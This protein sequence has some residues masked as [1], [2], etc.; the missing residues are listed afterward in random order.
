M[1]PTLTVRL[2]WLYEQALTDLLTDIDLPKRPTEIGLIRG[3]FLDPTASHLIINTTLGDNYYLHTQS[4]QPKALSRL[5]GVSIE[6][7]AWNPSH[8][9][10]STREILVAASDGNIYE[11]SIE[12]ANEFYRREEK[13]LRSV[14]KLPDGQPVTGIWVNIPGDRPEFRRV[15]IATSTKLLHFV[16][17]IGK[18]STDGS[19][20]IFAKF[21]DAERPTVQEG[22]E[23]ATSA[24]SFLAFSPDPTNDRSRDAGAP[25][26][27]YA[28][29]TIQGV[30][31]GKINPSTDISKLGTRMF[32]SSRLFERSRIPPSAA[33]SGRQTTSV[34]EPIKG[35]AMT[36]W[37]ILCI[38]EGRVV[39]INR[40]NEQVVYDQAVLEPGDKAIGLFAD[41]KKSTFW[42]FTSQEIFEISVQDEDRDI[43]KIMLREQKFEAA[44]QYA[45]GS[46]QKDAVATAS[47]DHLIGKKQYLEAASVY[48]KSSKPFEEVALVFIDND[49]A[50]AL[51]KYLLTKI[52][53]YK[54][55]QIMQRTM[56]ASWLVEIFMAKLNSLDDTITTK[57]ELVEGMNMSDTE[58]ELASIRRE[59]G[60]FLSKYKGDLD[61]KTTY[62][63][64][65]S[66]GREQELLAYATAINDYGYALSYWVQRERWKDVLDVL[67]KQ[68]N[69]AVFYKYGS[70]LMTHVPTE[71]VDILMR[72]TNLEPRN[73]IPA[74]LSYAKDHPGPLAQNQAARYL[75][76]CIN[77][78]GTTDAAV[79]NTLISIYAAH[80]S[81]S[82]QALMS[83]LSAQSAHPPP[84]YDA[85]FALRLCIQHNRV[86][87]CVHIY[88]LMS[89]YVEA[90]NLAL[91]HDEI[92]LAT[93]VA[94]RPAT[95]NPALRKKLWLAIA[96][97]V[98]THDG[99]GSV[100][101]A[102]DL[103]KRC[104]LL[105][106]E[107]L[108]PF[109]PD[110]VVIDDFKDEICAALES[111]SRHIDALA[112]DMDAAAAT[113]ASIRADV[114]R[115]DQRYAVVLPGERCRVCALPL[116][117]RQFF[118]FPSCQHGFH[119]DC[120]GRKVVEGSGL[121][122]R[123]RI[124]E[125]QASIGRGVQGARR[126]REVKELDALV[127]K[128]WYVI[129]G[130]GGCKTQWANACVQCAMQ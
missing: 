4:R 115:L 113:A 111:Y 79:H 20:S 114:K 30:R 17:K 55:S 51:R 125:L 74:L 130:F 38:V 86:Q 34:K 108:I 11:T 67:K 80:P 12:P 7:I 31:Y 53:M 65:S 44:L 9:T 39:A 29:L 82:E 97:K 63:V 61:K 10:A 129:C 112:Q 69:P 119:S 92:E 85:D 60:E 52:T 98:I 15:M 72:H 18:H 43:W 14:Y 35:I 106:I 40:L 123:N 91:K 56:I 13:Y 70:V 54:K 2:S 75:L 89:Q 41:L 118:V 100:K 83:Y 76:F 120:L 71:F 84:F 81:R 26:P 96:K 122:V 59:F 95:S 105:R 66:H 126:E 50:D 6:C 33:L 5:K 101:A 99:T 64:I 3:L 88:S 93:V 23:M 62:E 121:T 19:S 109:F 16:G 94:D 110:F 78:L 47:G 48:G 28:W 1:Q 25:D 8:P 58:K 27:T 90:V 73:L 116:L 117:S 57:A 32:N 87:S 49:E 24:P 128:E 104:E 103:L 68:T 21:F 127:G 46:K 77:Q 102:I 124:R 42:L 45:R 36:A 107:D 22:P 37:H